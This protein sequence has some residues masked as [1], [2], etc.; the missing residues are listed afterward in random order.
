MALHSVISSFQDAAR[1]FYIEVNIRY[2]QAFV[3]QVHTMLIKS[4]A[5]T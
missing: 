2:I 3:K 5:A 4:I 1:D